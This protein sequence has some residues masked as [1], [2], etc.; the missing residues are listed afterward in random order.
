MASAL[1][2]ADSENLVRSIHEHGKLHMAEVAA[3]RTPPARHVLPSRISTAKVTDLPAEAREA[4]D[5]FAA[6]NL[7]LVIEN[8]AVVPPAVQQ[9][10]NG[11]WSRTDLEHLLRRQLED[12]KRRWNDLSDALVDKLFQILDAYSDDDDLGDALVAAWDKASDFFGDRG[13]DVIDFYRK[14]ITNVSEHGNQVSSFFQDQQ[15]KIQ[16]WRANNPG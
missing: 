8:M 7:E 9:C 3:G 16:D 12:Y 1:S 13:A 5:A 14:I 11:D 15:K 6:D 2:G 10:L 4:L